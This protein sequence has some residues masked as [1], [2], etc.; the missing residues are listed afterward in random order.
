MPSTA[1]P[2]LVSR[3]A[4]ISEASFYNGL[5]ASITGS[6]ATVPRVVLR[7]DDPR[8]S[9][10]ATRGERLRLAAREEDFFEELM[11]P[12]LAFMLR[13][14]PHLLEAPVTTH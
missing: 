10:S 7:E 6:V 1:P 4:R 9:L 14:G 5:S 2:R 8:A 11:R 12:V 13:E 3:T